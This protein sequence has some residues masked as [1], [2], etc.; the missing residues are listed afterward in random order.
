MKSVYN[1]SILDLKYLEIPRRCI[2]MEKSRQRFFSIPFPLKLGTLQLKGRPSVRVKR[3]VCIYVKIVDDVF[4][5][6]RNEKLHLE[7]LYVNVVFS[8]IDSC[9]MEE[10]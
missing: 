1:F 6:K 8:Y 7:V 10:T 4:L 5:L 2:S 3:K 9:C